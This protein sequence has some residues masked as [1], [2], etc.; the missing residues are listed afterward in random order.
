MALRVEI[1]GTLNINQHQRTTLTATVTDDTGQTPPGALTYAWT[2]SRGSFVGATDQATAEYHA[3]F[4]DANPVD[5]RVTCEVTRAADAS[6]TVA[7]PSLRAMTELGIT[8]QFLNMYIT[9]TE[10]NT[11]A[12]GAQNLILY[13]EG[14]ADSALDAGSDDDL[15]ATVHVWRIR[16]DTSL[17]DLA[18]NND[19]S[20]HLFNYWNSKSGVS[21]YVVFSDGTH[22][23]ISGTPLRGD[24]DWTRFDVTDTAIQ[25]KFA[26]LADD[27]TLLVGAGDAGS[28]GLLEDTGSDTA[29]VRAAVAGT[30]PPPPDRPVPQTPTALKVELTS[31]TALLK[32]TG[33][34]DVDEYE[35]SVAEGSAP[36]TTWIPTGGTHTRFLVKGL[37][38]G[39]Q[40]TFAVRGRNE[41]GAGAASSPVT[42]RTPIASLHN[43]LFFKEFIHIGE[44]VSVHGSPTEIVRAVVDNDDNTFSDETDYDIDISRDTQPT[45]VDAVFIKSKGVTRHSGTPIGGSGTGWRN[46]DLPAT[47]SNWEGS[48]VNTT[49]LGFQ[50]H[51]M[52]LD[53][54]FTATSV[55]V[56]FQGTNIEIYQIMLLEF[57]MEIDANGDFTE[58]SPDY[59]DR[60]AVI[61]T[62]PDGGI[63]RSA[64]LGAEKSK[65]ETNFV[66]KVVPGKTLLESVDEFLYLM[67]QNPNIVFSQE[68][69]RY[70]ARVYPASF[71]MT[72]IPTRLRSDNKNLGD[73]VQFRV[74]EQ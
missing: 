32:W 44:R 72:R 45:R 33:V 41:A 18:F 55:R 73:I 28:I 16:Y 66:V 64:P 6:P 43:T 69:S 17:N 19:G 49:V 51:L 40:H 22:A 58:I 13:A 63:R 21:I 31:T 7:G 3:N 15:S 11:D 29:T 54:H 56:R 1:T 46:V 9:N 48:D 68:F 57:I 42:Q 62:S 34:S 25:G 23:E 38:R 37:R 4:T 65:W 36:G 59:V 12:N 71:L 5:V 61:H 14:S 74:G 52:L 27:S 53:S 70:P 35:V 2:A 39:T 20:G 30:P 26:A 10:R 47:V 50:H 24:A 60:A 8:G 67:S